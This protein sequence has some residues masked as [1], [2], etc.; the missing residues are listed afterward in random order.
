MKLAV[1]KPIIGLVIIIVVAIAAYAFWGFG[2]KKA[3]KQTTKI[4][5]VTVQPLIAHV[6]PQKVI[7]Y[8]S[9][10]FPNSVVLLAKTSGSI[11][12][13][14]FKPGQH[15]HQGQLLFSFHSNDVS[16]QSRA[17]EAK[18]LDARDI[19]TRNKNLYAKFKGGVSQSTLMDYKLKYES[20]LANYQE[21][22]HLK[23]IYAPSAGIISDTTL[24]VGSF[25]SE[26]DTL[27]TLT[28][29]NLIQVRYQI[30]GQYSTQAK[31]GQSVV[32]QPNDSNNKFNGIVSYVAPSI[33]SKN[34]LITVRADLQNAQNLKS[35]R[36]GQITQI[37]DAHAKVLAISQNFVKTDAQGFYVYSVVNGKAV[38]QYFKPGQVSDQGLI[39]VQSGLKAGTQIIT[40]NTNTLNPNQ[41]VEVKK[42]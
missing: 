38:Q 23:N 35:N 24:A 1:K 12:Q 21:S 29:S 15:I 7:A 14:N 37:T 39:A 13:I 9:T 32:F 33:D 31:A 11:T 17:L 26:G 41:A 27:A 16:N 5:M 40:S 34:H 3:T 30:P 22:L 28:N 6:I 36:F 42:S 19:Y 20:A 10:I 18:M 25:V 2:S 8:G 4:P